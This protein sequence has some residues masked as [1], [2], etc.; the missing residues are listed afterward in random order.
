MQIDFIAGA[1][2]GPQRLGETQIET[3]IIDKQHGHG[4]RD[5]NC[6]QRTLKLA[7]NSCKSSKLIP[8]NC[9]TCPNAKLPILSP[10]Q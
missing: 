2:A 10:I 8:K 6:F 3:R 1:K 5:E 4:L 9:T 7:A